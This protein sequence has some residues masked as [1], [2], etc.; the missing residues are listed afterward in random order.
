VKYLLVLLIG[1]ICGLPAQ[2]QQVLFLQGTSQSSD[3]VCPNIKNPVSTQNQAALE[4]DVEYALPED[5]ILEVIKKN[6]EPQPKQLDIKIPQ[7]TSGGPFRMAIWG[8]SHSAAAFLTEELIKS[9]GLDADSAL[10]SFI[11]PSMGRPGVRLPI[12]KYCQ[13]ANWQFNYAYTGVN[14]ESFGPALL[15]LNTAR[16]DSYL[17]VD[18]RSKKALTNNLKKLDILFSKTNEMGAKIG[19]QVDNRPEEIVEI[20]STQASKLTINS[21]NTFGVL[22]IRLIEGAIS[23]NGF[24]PTYINP[25]VAYVDTMGI[26]SATV[27]GWQYTN[28]NYIDQLNIPTN[29]DLIIL[30]YG[31]NE[32]SHLPFDAKRYADMLRNSLVSFRS[33]YP[34]A[35]CVLMGPTDRGIWHKKTYIMKGKHRV[36]KQEP[37]PNF[38][39]YSSV[40]QEITQI[41]NQVGKEF[42][43]SSWSWQNAMG[44]PGSA[45]KWIQQNPPLMAKDLI[46]LTVQGYQ[47]TG[48]D[49]SESLNLTQLIDA[50]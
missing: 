30:E 37:A 29:Y 11:P 32:G 5:E 20:N 35:S 39:M 7:R 33:I 19:I 25:P 49:L 18:F 36:L 12:R 46:H 6:T 41:Q 10:P 16:N 3:L 15:K 13:S 45:Y 23:L 38:L 43:C 8:D 24:V 31:T 34:S 47:Q 27:M 22:K 26:P 48:R 2:A 21:E 50:K 4:S 17:W 44:G 42:S 9:V 14:Q 1:F 40:H 28:K